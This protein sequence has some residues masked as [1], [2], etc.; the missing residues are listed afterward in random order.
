MSDVK[1][2]K[3]FTNTHTIGKILCNK[4]DHRRGKPRD[5]ES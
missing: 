3:C 1:H 2:L 4:H 5:N